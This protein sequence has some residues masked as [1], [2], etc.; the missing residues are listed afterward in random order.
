MKFTNKTV[1]LFDLD[2]TLVDSAPDLAMSGNLMLSEL[3]H[4]T[5][6]EQCFRD[7][8]GNGASVMV[9]R[10]LSGSKTIS[11]TLNPDL[12]ESA[13]ALFLQIYQTNAC[14]K[15]CLYPGVSDT[16]NTLKA[17][18]YRLVIVTNKPLTFIDP[19][20]DGLGING[21]FEL[22]IGGDSLPKRKPDPLPLLHVCQQLNVDVQQCLMIGDSKNDILAAKA[23]DMDSI[24]LT[25]GYNYGEDISLQQPECVLSNFEEIVGVL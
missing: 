19:I 3:K 12:L 22:I 16:L 1:L 14:V 7:W 24:G 15:T 18:G 10:A 8:I 17:Q 5:Y 23:A 11:P 13:L 4:P 25:Y 20:L 6:S 2:G 21:L 9:Q